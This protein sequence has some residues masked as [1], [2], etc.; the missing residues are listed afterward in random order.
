M[1]ATFSIVSRMEAIAVRDEALKLSN[2]ASTY[3][4]PL[5]CVRFLE[6]E[7]GKVDQKL[8]R[9]PELKPGASDR[10]TILLQS[11]NPECRHYVVLH[12]KAGTWDELVQSIRFFEEQT[13]L[14]DTGSLNAVGDK[15]LCWSCGKTGHYSW[16][17]P[18]KGKGKGKKGGGKPSGGNAG[19]PKGE[20]G[21]KGKGK[22]KKGE[23]GKGKAK[24]GKPKGKAKAK[25]RAVE[26]ESG[27]QVMAL[28]SRLRALND[29]GRRN[30]EPNPEPEPP[31]LTMTKG[32]I[33]RLNQSSVMNSNFTWLID[34]GATCHVLCA[35]SLSH[36]EVV[37]EH[38]GPLP[39]LLSASETPM[40]CTKLVDIRVK[41]G[42][43]AP[44][45]L[46]RVLVCK[47]GFNV[48]SSWQAAL[49]GW[50]TWLTSEPEESCLIKYT[51]RGSSMWV[52]L[53]RE[54][55]SWWAIAKEITAAKPPAKDRKPRRGAPPKP[56]REP[57]D[58]A[59]EVDQIKAKAL[60]RPNQPNIG[61]SLEITPFK[62]LLRAVKRQEFSDSH[63]FL[64]SV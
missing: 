40:E 49:S 36:Y 54:A 61:R 15:G 57:I 13:R 50:N 24:G 60:Q 37:K 63:M 5:D 4:R 16:Q 6:D 55:R 9:F 3:R 28:R 10:Q 25:G 12:G 19:A 14:C 34:S 17:C 62:F 51:D 41:F 20:K 48:I 23:K 31:R 59:M 52:P 22:G 53:V 30:T 18:D 26:D 29:P 45:V 58:D 43:L 64:T 35:D 21:E 56:G 7:L 39:V 27:E 32:E 38:S 8:H 1:H 42:K 33:E 11:V 44:V 47:I 2:K 46:Q